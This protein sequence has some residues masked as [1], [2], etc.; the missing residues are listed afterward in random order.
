MLIALK[1]GAHAA[2]NARALLISDE[3]SATRFPS[4]LSFFFLRGLFLELI[5]FLF[6]F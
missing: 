3:F 5:G 1:I 4:C 2:G 6:F